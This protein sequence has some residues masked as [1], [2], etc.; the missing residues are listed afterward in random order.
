M[1]EVL[2][3]RVPKVREKE[4]KKRQTKSPAQGGKPSQ[5]S[6][7]SRPRLQELRNLPQRGLGLQW[8][9]DERKFQVVE[10]Q[11]SSVCESPG[12]AATVLR[13]E[14]GNAVLD[15]TAGLPS[16]DN[17]MGSVVCWTVQNWSARRYEANPE[18]KEWIETE[19]V[20][21]EPGEPGMEQ[22]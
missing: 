13:M 7:P 15:G 8:V 20:Q 11:S 10:L 21:L 12:P 9:K 3:R 19:S 17:L 14:D 6:N 2:K 5:L 1:M 22:E 18:T 16:L 4:K